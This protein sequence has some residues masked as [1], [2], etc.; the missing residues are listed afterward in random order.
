MH[1]AALKDAIFLAVVLL[2]SECHR[3]IKPW[4]H[5]RPG[6]HYFQLNSHSLDFE[7]DLVV[8]QSPNCQAPEEGEPTLTR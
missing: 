5:L 4:Y 7:L 8:Y 6:V 1:E 2:S 3:L